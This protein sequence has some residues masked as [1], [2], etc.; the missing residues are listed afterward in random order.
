M[1]KKNL[2]EKKSSHLKSRLCSD[3]AFLFPTHFLKAPIRL[4]AKENATKDLCSHI[5]FQIPI[6][7]SH[8]GEGPKLGG[9]IPPCG[10]PAMVAAICGSSQKGK[11]VEIRKEMEKLTLS[12]RY[13]RR[14]RMVLHQSSKCG[15]NRSVIFTN[16]LQ[17]VVLIIPWVSVP[18][19]VSP[20]WS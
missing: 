20:N 19:N 6:S 3:H 12:G 2:S 1:L 7:L 17:G 10:T 5:L 13:S 15:G 4:E 8:H 14:N 16:I 11:S 9:G 18:Q